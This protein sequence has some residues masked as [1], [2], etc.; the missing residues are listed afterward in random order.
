MAQNPFDQLAKQYLEDFL[1]PIG[2]VS[3][4]HEV[5]GETKHVDVWFV[6]DLPITADIDDL[7]L[8]REIAQGPALIEPFSCPPDRDDLDACLLKRLWIKEE[9]RRKRGGGAYP[10]VEQ[11][12]LWILASHISKPLLKDF[13]ARRVLGVPGLY[14]LGPGLGVRLVAI[15]R[16]ERSPDSLWMRILGRGDVQKEAIEELY[17]LPVDD[18]RRERIMR[19]HAVW[20]IR[21]EMKEVREFLPEGIMAYPQAFLDWEQTTRDRGK[22]DMVFRLLGKRCGEVSGEVRSRIMSLPLPLLEQLGEDLLDFEGM[23][24]LLGWLDRVG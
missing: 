2:T 5:P 15:D 19:L 21:I 22:Q 20:S 1:S 4:Q 17:G 9:E 14:T 6:P 3:R 23:G 10:L 24:D 13:F 16:L 11:P 12:L 18:P 7:G 8:L